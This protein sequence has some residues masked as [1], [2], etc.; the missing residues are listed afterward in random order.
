MNLRTLCIVPAFTLLGLSAQFGCNSSGPGQPNI[1]AD[2]E[3]RA[4]LIQDPNIDS[5]RIIAKL[6]KEGADYDGAQLQFGNSLLNFYN[7]KYGLDTIYAFSQDMTPGYAAGPRSFFL[8]DSPFYQD[9]IAITV[10]G[11]FDIDTINSPATKILR[12]GETVTYTWTGSANA[13]NY[14][15]AAV[16]EDSA[17]KSYGYSEY[18]PSV[19]TS[20][21]LPA[22]AFSQSP[23]PD[24]DTGLYNIY[25][26]AINGVPDSA[27]TDG[28]LPVPLPLQ[29]PNNIN[30]PDL[31]GRFGSIQITLIDTVR[32][33]TSK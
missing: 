26:Y 12:A 21:T 33:Q 10:G 28:L 20:G 9:T 16:L 4:T 2:Y 25:V 18:L 5:S 19:G 23:S 15:M 22:E 31:I 7:T 8:D 30:S 32:A 3:L 24:L 13:Q 29:F 27:M 17:Y 6:F 14:V 11:A 1:P